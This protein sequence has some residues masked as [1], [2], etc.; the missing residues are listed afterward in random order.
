MSFDVSGGGDDEIPASVIE[1]M[2]DSPGRRAYR[3]TDSFGRGAITVVVEK[4]MA[5]SDC[6]NQAAELV[7]YEDVVPLRAELENV[8]ADLGVA[9]E[10]AREAEERA[11]QA[12]DAVRATAPFSGCWAPRTSLRRR[13]PPRK[14]A[15]ERWAA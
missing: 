1:T 15:T 9:R 7:G 5:R 2:S 8:R 13:S 4:P 14:P 6:L 3:A 10:R 12:D 11:E